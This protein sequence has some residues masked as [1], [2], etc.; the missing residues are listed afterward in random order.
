MTLGGL[1]LLKDYLQNIDNQI[2]DAGNKDYLFIVSSMIAL[3]MSGGAVAYTRFTGE[4]GFEEMFVSRYR[5]I[6]ITLFCLGYLFAL[7]LIRKEQGK[8]LLLTFF[9][10]LTA[11]LYLYSYYF[12]HQNNVNFR[13][14]LVAGAFNF[15]YHNSWVFYPF[16]NDWTYQVDVANSEA[17]KMGIYELPQLP[18]SKLQQEINKDTVHNVRDLAFKIEQKKDRF[19]LKNETLNVENPLEIEQNVVL[20]SKRNTYLLPMNRNRNKSKKDFL[21]NQ[22]LF[23]KGFETDILK[24]TFIPDEYTIGLLKVQDGKHEIQYSNMKIRL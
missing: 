17:I 24:N 2:V 22:N 11:I 8:R 10:P 18:F 5:F 14:K 3:C 21:F 7:L 19:T 16:D 9:F 4:Y 15:K 1:T 20:K 23:W 12:L 13:E 6:S